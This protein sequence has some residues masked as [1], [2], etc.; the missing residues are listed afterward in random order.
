MKLVSYLL[1]GGALLWAGLLAVGDDPAPEATAPVA[2]LLGIGFAV[3]TTAGVGEGSVRGSKR[4]IERSDQPT[5]FWVAV[6]IYYALA[7]LMLAG[8]I[9]LWSG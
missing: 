2:A 1:M 5:T 8:A 7:G 9:A 4:R 3:W 6:T